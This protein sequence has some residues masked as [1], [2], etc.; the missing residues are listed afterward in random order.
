MS[1]R[2]GVRVLPTD[3]PKRWRFNEDREDVDVESANGDRLP[4]SPPRAA[5]HEECSDE[6]EPLRV[7]KK[8]MRP[9]IVAKKEKKNTAAR[10][11]WQS[12]AKICT[13]L[14]PNCCIPGN[15]DAKQAWREKV[16]IFFIMIFV[17]AIF[18]GGFGFA[19][20]L[21][22]EEETIYTWEDIWSQNKEA[23]VVVHGNIYDME[24]LIHKHPGGIDGILRYLGKDASKLFPRAPPATLPHSCLNLDKIIGT[25]LND[26]TPVCDDFTKEDILSGLPCHDFATGING[27]NKYLKE[28]ERG[29]LAYSGPDLEFSPGYLITIY[30]RVYNVT[31]YINNI[32]N[33]LSFLI[34]EDHENAFLDPTL[35][36]LVINKAN[37]D[38]T[39]LYEA[40]F[41][42]NDTLK[43]MDELFYV[44][45]VDTRFNP[46]CFALNI[47]VYVMLAV[48]GTV[49]V[50]QFLASMRY[51]SPV[52]RTFNSEDTDEPVII[53]VPCYNE[54]DKELRK[55]VESVLETTYTEENKVLVVIAD[56]IITGRGERM[57]TP[58]Y[59]ADILG[60]DID[61]D[62]DPTY[63]YQSIGAA[64]KNRARIYSGVHEKNGRQLKYIVIVKSGNKNEQVSTKPGNRGKRDSQL[65]ITGFFNRI[66]NTR[67]MTDLDI[68]L[69]MA[70]G[71]LGIVSKSIKFLMTIDADTR[72][73]RDSVSHMIFNMKKKPEVLALCGETKVDNKWASWIT[74][75]QVFE[76]YINHHMKKAFESV[77]GTVT[78]LPGCFTMYRIISEDGV[79]LLASDEVFK[80]YAR[81][82]IETLHEKNLYHLGEDRLLTTLLLLFFADKRLNFVPEARC[83]TIVPHTL[84]ILLSQRR[85]WINST[86]HNLFELLQVKTMCGIC[87]FSM[88]TVVALDLISTMILPAS[89]IYM[90][91]LIYIFVEKG[92]TVSM[93]LIVVFALIFGIQLVVFMLRSKWVYLW[94]F[95]MFMTLGVPVFYILLPLYAFWHMDDLSWGQTRKI[96]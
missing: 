74:M 78:C 23:W 64:T 49:L 77:F 59:L 39:E 88:K 48:V 3:L 21:I 32:K 65:I 44:G 36:S 4:P 89:T 90:G 96:K 70:L 25:P 27:T 29:V 83:W 24:N 67:E 84:K 56:G 22:C 37:Q 43:C 91:Y 11:W 63:E 13:F 73:D 16:A 10:R 93:L 86:V 95:A 54:G 41:V 12:F 7:P 34:E 68:A 58:E 46:V 71:G 20:L 8:V 31:D 15:K 17:S 75:I 79:P 92:I 61:E 14:V 42:G 50:L 62:E 35:N 53:M 85:R 9:P 51:V 28:Y 55:T 47:G 57:S 26:T 80:E 87:F 72:V 94:W 66:Y 38:A 2:K 19:P 76:Y 18:V 45:M 1:E 5:F 81:N 52:H 60:F 33:E 69:D 40:L 6:G 30:D 82:D